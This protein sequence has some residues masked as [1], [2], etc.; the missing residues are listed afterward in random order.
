MALPG[1]GCAAWLHAGAF[2]IK[3]GYQ[4][5]GPDFSA[6]GYWGKVGAWSN[7]TNVQGGVASAKYAFT[8]NFNINADFQSYKAA[9]G[10]NADGSALHSPLQQGDKLSRY[11]VGLNY[12]LSSSYA[13]DLGYEEV[14]WDLKGQGNVAAGKPKEK[15]ITIGL[16]H[17]LNKNTS[18][19]LLYQIVQYKDQGT[20]F[21]GLGDTDGNVAV[22]QFQIKF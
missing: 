16:G 5:V 9:Y 7:P 20:G 15:Y 6:P 8:P 19:K 4:Y 12:G 13:A 18:F 11:Q 14:D 22:G 2:S 17:T 3:G 1:R 10:L 21:S